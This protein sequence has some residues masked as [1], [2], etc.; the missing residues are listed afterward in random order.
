[1]IDA[2]GCPTFSAEPRP[3]ERVACFLR[4]AIVLGLPDVITTA[5]QSVQG[6][7]AHGERHGMRILG[8]GLKRF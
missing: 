6:R 8:D 4:A 1:V 3:G 7:R 2:I 5:N